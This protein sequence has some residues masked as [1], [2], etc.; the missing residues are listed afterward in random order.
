LGEGWCGFAVVYA[1]DLRVEWVGA[2]E[3]CGDGGDGRG[4]GE[5]AGGLG[6]V[7]SACDRFGCGELLPRAR[8][9]HDLERGVRVLP[10]WCGDRRRLQR[11][12]DFG[13]VREFW[14]GEHGASEVELSGS[15]D[16]VGAAAVGSHEHGAAHCFGDAAAGA[17]VDGV[18]GDVVG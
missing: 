12:R 6:G 10:A 4:G 16:A 15:A 7:V 8:F 5:S 17:D 13:A 2:D 9:G 3:S 11:Q 1:C 14:G 18:D